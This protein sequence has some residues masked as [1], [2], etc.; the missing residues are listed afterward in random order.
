[1]ADFRELRISTDELTGLLDKQTFYE[2][3]QDLLD[4]ATEGQ[5]YA[6]IFFDLENFKIFNVNYGYEIGDELLASIGYIIK[7]VFPGQL[8]SRFSG[9]H[10]VACVNSIQ[11][12][13]SIKSIR[14]RIKLIRKSVNVELKAGIYIFDGQEKDVIKCCDRARMA[15]ISIKKKYDVEYRIYD[16]QLGGNLKRKQE[17]LD[18]LDDAIARKYIKVY[19]QPIVRAITG[20]ICGWEALVRW[21]DPIAGMVY[22]N[23]FIPVLE[24]YRLIPKIDIFVIEEVLSRYHE[25]V[26]GKMEA[27]PVSINLSRLDF[28][29]IDLVEFLDKKVEEYKCPKNLFHF[30]VTESALME[31]PQFI[32]EQIARM[33]QKGYIVWMDDFGSGYSSL[34]VLKNYEFDLI[35]I[36]MDFLRDFETTDHGKII[37]RH[38]VSMIKNLNIHT[39]VEGVETQE[40]YDFMKSIGCEMIQGYLIGRPMPYLEGLESLAEDGREFEKA[41]ERFF[42]EDLGKIDILRQNP[43]QN[44]EN[45]KIENPLPLAVLVVQ[46]G[47]WKFVY[48]NSGFDEIV[49]LFGQKDTSVL[50]DGLN[51]KRNNWSHHG[52][53]LEI[54]EHSKNEKSVESMDFIELG[55]I[56]NMRVRFICQSEDASMEAYL[57]SM[58]LL[59]RVINT[60]YDER[61]NAVSHSM[62]SL[63]ECVDLF[64]LNGDYFENIYLNDSRLHL[65]EESVKPDEVVKKISEEL[66]HPDDRADFGR[67]MD[68]STVTERLAEERNGASV[69]FFRI[70]DA[71]GKYV[72]KSITIYM[73]HFEGKDV[74]MSCVGEASNEIARR[75]TDSSSAR[76]KNGEEDVRTDNPGYEDI[77]QMVPIGVFWKD[78]HRRFLGANQMFLDYYGLQSVEDIIG[79]TDED[80][81]WHINPEPFRRDELD[82]INNGRVIENVRG[83]CIVRG[84]VRKIIASKKPYVVNRKIKGLVGFF[85][86]VTDEQEEH[87]K[88]ERLTITDVLTGLFNRR[89]FADIIEKYMEQYE[90]DGS[91]FVLLM[92]DIDRFKMINDTQGH[93]FGDEVLKRVSGVLKRVAADNSVVFRF[94]GD[95]FVIL[96]HYKNEAELESVKHEINADLAKIEQI[97]AVQISIRV[98]IGTSIYSEFNSISECLDAADKRM[99]IEKERHKKEN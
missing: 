62:F 15:C 58:R 24:E 99:Y 57:I 66:V 9:D 35:K 30:E 69:G 81:G 86:D 12:V 6:F 16:D 74:L 55:R 76:K 40:Q 29:V 1:M 92:I 52:R 25:D 34:N 87:A 7:D 88:L 42:Y 72:W 47:V 18:S 17:I 82:V 23:E 44:I 27:V 20:K 71:R 73:M 79:K 89:A 8:I 46:N 80:M 31:N 54:C 19:Y 21:I 48:T 97:G 85:K 5:E 4:C 93:D 78:I 33:R 14:D 77:L 49:N 10:F 96:R 39:L 90:S 94:G 28:E 56:V 41:D 22:P 70:L 75:M 63:Y 60:S 3:A 64:G 50:E 51:N 45:K 38:I 61:I 53:F 95:E 65:Q 67:F 84:S 83:E 2:C 36:D 11:V 37:L 32:M 26:E 68:F 59:S 91:D 43:L 98:S 13:P